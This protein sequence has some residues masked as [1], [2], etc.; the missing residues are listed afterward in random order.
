MLVKNISKED[1][2]D[3]YVR[4]APGDS[5]KAVAEKM[6]KPR[7]E[8]LDL[9]EVFS[10]PVL[11]AVVVEDERPVGIVEWA[12]IVDHVVLRGKDPERTLAHDA[13]KTPTC[14]TGETPLNEVV[15]AIVENGLLAVVLCDDEGKL[16]GV[17][18]VFDAVFL[19]EE[20]HH[21]SEHAEEQP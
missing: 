3:E 7:Q 17:V 14:F 16:S 21:A 20:L 1:F 6:G 8:R 2:E 5:L 15:N 4:V 19:K 18:S 12:T 10:T 9:T 13:M 11:V